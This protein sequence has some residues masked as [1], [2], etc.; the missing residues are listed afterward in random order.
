MLNKSVIIEG[1]YGVKGEFGDGCLKVVMVIV[2]RVNSRGIM[3][4]TL[5]QDLQS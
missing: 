3:L 5:L 1:Y 4:E 2:C